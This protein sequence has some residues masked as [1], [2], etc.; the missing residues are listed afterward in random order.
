M[1]LCC[2]I[3]PHNTPPHKRDPVADLDKIC[4]SNPGKGVHFVHM[5]HIDVFLRR[6]I[7]TLL[8][9]AGTLVFFQYLLTPLLPFLLALGLS[10]LAEPAVER[11]R[12]RLK[13]RRSFAAAVVTTLVLVVCGGAVAFLTLR[14]VVELRGW[15]EALPAALA[16]F[17]SVWNGFLDR[18]ER[19][20]GN[21]PAFLRSALDLLAEQLERDT[22]S[23]VGSVGEWLMG[24][25]SAILA[26]L[27]GAGLF[28]MTTVLAMYFTSVSYPAILAFLKRQLP[29]PWQSRCREAARCFRST[30]LKWLR[31]EALL[32]LTT[33]GVLLIGFT[34]MGV[35]FALLAAVF[36]ALVD[37]LPVLGTGTVLGPWAAGCF[38]LG[39]TQRGLAL[40]AI[41][42]AAFLAHTL[43]EPRLLAG[44]V[45]LPPITALLAMYV[46][47]HF[48]GVGGMV[49]LPV[50]LL[51]VKQ[52]QD[53]GVMRI[54]R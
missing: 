36:T 13:V 21:S 43:L 53:A 4:P 48:M 46:G 25:A 52:L 44:Q 22:P 18:V 19:W 5:Q 29:A 39:D 42:G 41:Y 31:A 9:L 7:T 1:S 26:A 35:D 37:A 38:L 17:P 14:L 8:W 45:G 34:W 24:E 30:M 27:P 23:L 50:V 12:R 16:R 47:F 20:Y 3:L 6:T 54:W 33:F 51:L 28:V 32:L 40:L 11:L 10:A 15:S 49:L 2:V